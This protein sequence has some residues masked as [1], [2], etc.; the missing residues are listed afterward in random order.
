MATA[1]ATTDQVSPRRSFGSS[2]SIFGMSLTSPSTLVAF[3]RGSITRSV[4]NQP[5]RIT[6]KVEAVVKK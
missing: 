3:S 6:R 4:R 1:I 2:F 5:T